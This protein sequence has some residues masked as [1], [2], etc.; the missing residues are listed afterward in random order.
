MTFRYTPW[1]WL[2][3]AIPFAALFLVARER[4][5]ERIARRFVSERLRGGERALRSARPWLLTIALAAAVFALAGP[6]RGFRTIPV[7]DR[8]TNRVIVLDVSNSMLA[9]DVGTSR[10]T[11]AKAIAKRLLDAS[12]GRVGLVEFEDSPQIVAPLTN[13]ADAVEA[14]L[15]SIQAGEVGDPGSDFGAAID[16]ALKLVQ[17]DPGT[18]ADIV[19]ISDGEDQGTKLRDALRRARERGVTISTVLVG[20]QEGSTIPLA[21]GPLRDDEGNVVTTRAH[22]GV[23][24]QIANATEGTFVASPFPEHALDALLV[25]HGGMAKQHNVRVPIDRYQWPLGV[26]FLFFLIGSFANRGAE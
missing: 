14:M 17:N 5:R 13:D 23:L 2:L 22:P 11:A 16:A 3:L 7:T 15:D 26:A 10:L 9:E 20:T 18:K 21:E 25:S 24:Q 19:L 6:S 1:L 4:M 8:Q 12:T